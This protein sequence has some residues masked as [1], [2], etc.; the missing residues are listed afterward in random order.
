MTEPDSPSLQ[1]ADDR[2]IIMIVRHGEKP[3][4]SESQFGLTPHGEHDKHSLSVRGWVRAGALV[5]LFAPQD[6]MPQ[7]G[8]ARPD[9]IYASGHASDGSHRPVQ[10]VTP[11]AHRLGQDIHSGHSAG[12]EAA[13]ARDLATRTGATLVSWQHEAI[14]QIARH[15]GQVDPPTPLDWADDRFDMV[16]TFTR[17]AHG[18]RFTQIPQL[19]LAGDR[20][21]PLR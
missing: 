10:T 1:A 5:G 18:W 3:D 7:T 20:S 6:A 9:A 19:L 16:W 21:D 14:P 13:L 11:L 15:L 12:Q 2:A 8:L 4:D 17:V